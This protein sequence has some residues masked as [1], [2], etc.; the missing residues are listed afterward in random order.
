LQKAELEVRATKDA[1]DAQ[2]KLFDS[3]QV[4]Y[5]EG[6]IAQKDVNDAQVALS[7][8]RNQYEQAVKHLDTLQSV[9]REQSVKGA[10]AQRD[11]AKAHEESA[12]ALFG[13]SRILSPIDGVVT[14]RP[15]YAGELPPTNGPMITVMDISQIIARAHVSQDDARQLKVGDPANILAVDGGAPLAGKVSLI[16]PALDPAS[17]T[18]EVWVQVPN[19]GDRLKPGSSLRVEMIAKTIPDALSIPASAVLTS[20]SGSTS[21]IVVDPQNK[22][23]KKSV[24]LGIRDGNKVQVAEGLQSGERVVTIGAF[25]LGKLESEVLEKT[26]VQIQQP[27]E[28]EEED[29]K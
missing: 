18:V 15:V 14:D 5:R 22:P 6:A 12:Q 2:Q 1:M 17:T 4:L 24:T 11:A 28:E 7:Q 13:F 19:M 27:K 29:E 10:A 25:E 3:R 8:A 9:S 21:V 23:H 26:T 16:S 20:S